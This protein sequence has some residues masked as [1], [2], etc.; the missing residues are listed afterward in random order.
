MNRYLFRAIL[1]L[2]IPSCQSAVRPL[3]PEPPANQIIRIDADSIATL[4]VSELIDSITRLPLDLP[5]GQPLGAVDQVAAAKDGSFYLVDRITNRIDVVDPTGKFRFSIDHS[6]T[7]KGRYRM[8]GEFRIDPADGTLGIV[9]PLQQKF[10]RLDKQGNVLAE[11]PLSWTTG[12]GNFSFLDSGRL[13]FC[14]GIP[15]DQDKFR[16]SL[17]VTRADGTPVSRLMRY[18]QSSSAVIT[19]FHPLQ[20]SGGDTWYLP[21]YRNVIYRVDGAGVKPEW[22]LDFGDHWITPEY[23]YSD[24]H[25]NDYH[26]IQNDLPKLPFVYFV[27]YI[28]TTRQVLLYFSFKGGDYLCVFDRVTGKQRTTRLSAE[29]SALGLEAANPNTLYDSMIISTILPTLRRAPAE[30]KPTILLIHFKKI[31]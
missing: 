28:V 12:V 26:W 21:I 22:K 7:G 4:P 27:N 20:Q 2:S 6:G 30:S 25:T 11:Y 23:A 31:T 14:R 29:Y 16:Y 18:E 15:P 1:L 5:P 9:D 8:I 10:V 3:P 24:E 17:L 19:P 13:L